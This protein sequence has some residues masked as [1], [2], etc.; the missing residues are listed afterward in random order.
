M[1]DINSIYNLKVIGDGY[2]N[3]GPKAYILSFY[4][5]DDENKIK[6]DG[7]VRNNELILWKNE[8]TK[9][10]YYEKKKFLRNEI[11]FEE[12]KEIFNFNQINFE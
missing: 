2:D 7:E 5:L 8:K 3:I 1:C 10:K 9:M 12:F 4:T 11:S 6:Y